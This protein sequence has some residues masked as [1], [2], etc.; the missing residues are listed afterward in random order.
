MG[1]YDS[2]VADWAKPIRSSPVAALKIVWYALM[3][4]SPSTHSGPMLLGMSWP[5]KL[6]KH[7]LLS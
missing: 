4:V 1:K 6:L 7:K 5:M 3:N 2:Q